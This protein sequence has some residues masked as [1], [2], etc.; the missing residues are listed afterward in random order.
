MRRRITKTKTG[1]RLMA[2]EK[3]I[4]RGKNK[5]LT[6]GQVAYRKAKKKREDYYKHEDK[7]ARYRP[8]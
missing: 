4:S 3:R 6:D 2:R 5:G 8:K 1:K 7:L